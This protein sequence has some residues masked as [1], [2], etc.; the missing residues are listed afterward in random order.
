M[1][2]NIF[3]ILMVTLVTIS[4]ASCERDTF[5]YVRIQSIV[6][7]QTSLTLTEGEQATLTAIVYPENTTI[8]NPRLYWW[9]NNYRVATVDDYGRVTAVMQG[10]AG[11]YAST[12]GHGGG[13]SGRSAVTVNLVIPDDIVDGVIVGGVR[14]ATRNVGNP[15]MFA[16]APESS[17]NHFHWNRR[18]AQQHSDAWGWDGNNADVW[19]RE[20]DPCPQGWRVPTEAELRALTNANSRWVNVNGVNGRLLG[21]APNHIFLPSGNYWGSTRRSSWSAW[22]LWSGD[23]WNNLSVREDNFGTL[24][25]I[26]CVAN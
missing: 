20:N 24:L 23:N 26:R 12:R 5:E 13:I 15:G 7:S 9:S 25:F 22:S 11:I 14:W 18:T 8:Q 19:E 21:V 4:F 10:Q 17:G 3:T 2:K 6:F 16:H 1:N